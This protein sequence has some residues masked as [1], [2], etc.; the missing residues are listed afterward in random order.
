MRKLS[1]ILL[2]NSFDTGARNMTILGITKPPTHPAGTHA[3]AG[4]LRRVC[5]EVQRTG[6]PFSVFALPACII[7]INN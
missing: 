3:S 5:A 2:I 1:K 4:Q 7:S 6:G